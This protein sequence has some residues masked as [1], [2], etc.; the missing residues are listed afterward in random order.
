MYAVLSL[1]F[2]TCWRWAVIFTTHSL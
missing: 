2:D 1:D